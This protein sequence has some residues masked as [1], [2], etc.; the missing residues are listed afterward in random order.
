MFALCTCLIVK[1]MQSS[2]LTPLGNRGK[3]VQLPTESA[4]K[5]PPPPRPAGRRGGVGGLRPSARRRAGSARA[6]RRRRGPQSVSERRA[7]RSY[8][9]AAL[10]SAA[11]RVGCATAAPMVK[12][13]LS[14]KS[15][16]VC[17]VCVC[18]MC[19][20][21]CLPCQPT[22]RR[23]ALS[24]VLLR[25][26]SDRC[27]PLWPGWVPSLPSAALGCPSLLALVYV[28]PPTKVHV[29]I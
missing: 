3:I 20:V 1:R 28:N 13:T 23:V 22:P 15:L 27:P 12:S 9:R 11:S 2:V 5:H 4:P 29:R 26:V 24:V 16:K 10:R 7:E 17:F 8:V 21:A 14:V 6:G 19:V 18:A 25:S